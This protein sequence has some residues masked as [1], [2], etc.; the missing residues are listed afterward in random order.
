LPAETRDALV[1]S[2]RSRPAPQRRPGGNF[3][4]NKVAWLGPAFIRLVLEAVDEQAVTLSNA[5]GLL[6]V[7]VSQFDTLRTTVE[8]RAAMG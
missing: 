5:A 2:I 7:K 8:T 3:Y 1:D 6:G 4:L